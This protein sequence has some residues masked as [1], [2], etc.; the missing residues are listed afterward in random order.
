MLV[1]SLFLL[2]TFQ[3]VQSTYV[4]CP[5][6]NDLNTDHLLLDCL[7]ERF[8]WLYSVFDNLPS[9]VEFA[10]W[11]RC[12]TGV[13][14]T[15]L[16]GHRHYCSY[17]SI[18]N[19]THTPAPSD[20]LDWC[21]FDHQR[22]YRELEEIH[23]R[24]TPPT[25]TNY[26]CSHLTN[27]SCD[28]LDLCEQGFCLCDQEAIACIGNNS[29]SVLPNQ[30]EKKDLNSPGFTGFPYNNTIVSEV[31]NRT[32]WMEASPQISDKDIMLDELDITLNGTM[33]NFTEDFLLTNNTLKNQSQSAGY[34]GI[35][36][37]DKENADLTPVTKPQK[38]HGVYP[39]TQ[40]YT[41]HS[42]TTNAHTHPLD[43]ATAVPP[44]LSHAWTNDLPR[45]LEKDRGKDEELQNGTMLL[46][47][48]AVTFDPTAPHTSGNPDDKTTAY[49]ELNTS[50]TESN[51]M[52][53][54]DESRESREKVEDGESAERSH[55]EE[56]EHKNEEESKMSHGN[57][58]PMVSTPS[59]AATSQILFHPVTL[60][61]PAKQN[62]EAMATPTQL[63]PEDNSDESGEK[64]SSEDEQIT[65]MLQVTTPTKITEDQA[66]LF[67]IHT[68]ASTHTHTTIQRLSEDKEATDTESQDEEQHSD[69]DNL[70]MSAEI[71]DSIAGHMTTLN[72]ITVS[73]MTS[74]L[75]PKNP[76]QHIEVKANSPSQAT[77]T[78]SPKTT[79]MPGTHQTSHRLTTHT[80]LTRPFTPGT[81]QAQTTF[82]KSPHTPYTSHS[83]LMK[84]TVTHKTSV[85]LHQ[86]VPVT[87]N[88]KTEPRPL[89]TPRV[90]H[91]PK[92]N[93]S[94]PSSATTT[95][96]YS[97]EEEEEKHEEM[98]RELMDSSQE[99]ESRK[100]LQRAKRMMPLFAWPLLEAAGLSE[101][102]LHSQSDE[103]SMTF[104]QYSS[105]GA[106][107][108]EFAA[109]GE[110]L[111][112]L[113]GRCPQEYEHY[114]C[115]CGQQGSGIPQDHLDQCCFF[116]QCCLEQLTLLGCRRDRKLNIHI[117]CHNGRPQCLGVS[118]CDR[119][120]C[121]CDRTTAEC[122]AA[123]HFNHSITS[124]CSGPRPPCTRRPSPPPQRADSDS[125]Q[126]SSETAESDLQTSQKRPHTHGEPGQTKPAGGAREQEGKDVEQPEA[127]EDKEEEEEEKEEEEGG[128]EN[129]EI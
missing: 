62:T 101:I 93:T 18:Q 129:E 61:L 114:G 86:R 94:P 28:S 27:N 53:T 57:H 63:S 16:Q 85:T 82:T 66:K 104:T 4:F 112:C 70:Q 79:N 117:N 56:K 78:I 121:V 110:M 17:I 45:E 3:N 30:H 2:S 59:G 99:A 98:K 127:E 24:K 69:E 8:N 72:A 5:D 49:S 21:C 64:I 92:P 122:M 35:P 14:P 95:Q 58:I 123:S 26:T 38:P 42:E 88:H 47:T 124:Q 33:G 55:A 83:L 75:I 37:S 87:H 100:P 40:T 39:E 7:G 41:P 118:V 34:S 52:E 119:L 25:H 89:H 32:E 81:F 15:D 20:T 46:Q 31:L 6:T 10:L 77:S 13:C 126:E 29:H 128:G 23:C 73:P 12:E 9:L 44:A 84:P 68:P 54:K 76:T 116:H 125:S 91:T 80:S 11:M 65:E 36:P 90:P 22:C 96:G 115:Y 67:E 19:T 113:T 108:G 97:E 48:T 105:T 1:M 102:L 120:Q 43:S 74:Y 51:E 111:H 71:Q 60:S 107:I 106:V 103:C 109:L 50:E